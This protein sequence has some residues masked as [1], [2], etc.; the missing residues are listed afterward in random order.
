M[1]A[2]INKAIDLLM[3][4]VENS[5][6][7]TRQA[8]KKAVRL[9]Q[10][11]YLA[12]IRHALSLLVQQKDADCQRYLTE[13]RSKLLECKERIAALIGHGEW[14][15]AFHR[16]VIEY[17][18]TRARLVDEIRL[19]PNFAMELLERLT[20]NQSLSETINWLENAMTGK[21]DLYENLINE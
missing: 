15:D 7:E 21:K 10:A 20:L 2:T 16:D 14:Q 8:L 1:Q 18:Y 3:L 13:Q 9:V 12:T 19:F 4:D 11:D 5:S 17:L 6:S